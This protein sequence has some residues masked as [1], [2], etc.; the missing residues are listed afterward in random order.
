MAGDGGLHVVVAAGRPLDQPT[1]WA[2]GLVMSSA[3][4]AAEAAAQL[5]AGA[6]GHL[7][8]SF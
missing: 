2:G 8:P 6:F 5:R 1:H 7:E 4:R 3:D